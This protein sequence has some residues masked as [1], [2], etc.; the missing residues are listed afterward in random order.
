VIRA[1]AGINR[2]V[3]GGRRGV[4]MLRT[5][6]M[7]WGLIVLILC[8]CGDDKKP[9]A[10]TT[11]D[12]EE[13]LSPEVSYMPLEVGNMWKYEVREQGITQLVAQTVTGMASIRNVL[14]YV[15]NQKDTVRVNALNEY[16]VIRDGREIIQYKLN[17][18]EGE[19]WPLGPNEEGLEVMGMLV[20]RRERVEVPAGTF[21]NC[22]QFKFFSMASMDTTY[23]WLA[24]ELGFIKRMNSV[25][26]TLFS[27]L[28]EAIISGKAYP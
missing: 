4:S 20:S 2:E 28:L 10:T 6:M 23:M 11:E 17:A 1:A 7:M 22:L 19:S 12:Q 15:I 5:T 21:S 25:D 27:V 13:P 9:S 16:V 18:E 3:Y 24:P 26:D 8:A 14:W